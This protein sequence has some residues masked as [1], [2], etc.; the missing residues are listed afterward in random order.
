MIWIQRIP[1]SPNKLEEQALSFTSK[2]YRNLFLQKEGN[3]LAGKNYSNFII[4]SLILFLTF[5]AIGFGNGSFAYLEDKF[6]NPYVNWLSVEIPS[7]RKIDPILNDLN[8]SESPTQAR[9]GY[10]EVSAYKDLI[11]RFIN[12]ENGE[13][14]RAKGRSFSF[15][16]KGSNHPLLQELLQQAVR[17]DPD[18]FHNENDLAL[19]VTQSFMNEFGYPVDAPYVLTKFLGKDP[20][21]VLALPLPVRTVVEEI[22]GKNQFAFTRHFFDARTQPSDNPFDFRRSYHTL[23]LVEA[24]SIKALETVRDINDF[25]AST[26]QYQDM[27]CRLPAKAFFFTRRGI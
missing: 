8:A 25:F 5:F 12:L 23:I 21:T 16:G 18:G 7:G 14:E 10:K 26:P 1:P 6:N 15:K 2:T 22:P 13:F 4:L 24:D 3:A 9:F 27:D 20:D 19:I 17:G 11:T